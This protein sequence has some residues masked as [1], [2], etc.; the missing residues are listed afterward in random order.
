M[1]YA[2]WMHQTMHGHWLMDNRFAIDQQPGLT[3]NVYFFALGQIARFVGIPLASNLARI[4]FGVLFGYLLIQFVRRFNTGVF[5]GKLAVSLGVFGAGLGFLVWHDFGQDL[6]LDRTLW[7]KSMTLGKLPTDVWQPEGFAFPSLLTNGLFAVS[8]CLILLTLGAILDVEDP[9]CGWRPIVIGAVSIGLL[10]NIHSYDVL[11]VGLIGLGLLAASAGAKRLTWGW[12]GRVGLIVLG[13]LPGALWFVNVLTHDPVFAARAATETYAANF[14]ALVFGY[15]PLL[16][17]GVWGLVSRRGD[18][19]SRLRRTIGIGLFT[20]MFVVL[21]LTAPAEAGYALNLAGWVAVLGLALGA[22]AC[23]AEEDATYNLV[24]AWAVVGLVAPYFPGLFQ[25]KLAMGLELPWALLSAFALGDVLLSRHRGTRNLFT[26][27]LLLLIAATNIR[28]MLRELQL[29]RNDVSETTVQPAYLKAQTQRILEYLDRRSSRRCVVLCV[30][31][32]PSPD[33]DSF[34]QP[35]PDSYSSPNLPELNPILSGL[36]GVYTYAGHW[37]ET[38]DYLHR[39]QRLMR[40]LFSPRATDEQRRALIAE[41]GANYIVA[42][43]ASAFTGDT[44]ADLSNLGNVV[45]SGTAFELI[46]LATP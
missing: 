20:V 42:P 38:P 5:V 25:R 6:V 16:G 41:T 44:F 31:G 45:V 29:I 9:K 12:V 23:L 11:L 35:V 32:L 24:L 36:G 22:I 37:S 46:E 26:A 3:I 1:V 17:L 13:V 2:A 15:L 28:W 14:R 34:G 7:M 19:S 30:P 10:M 33:I 43:M 39:R 8:L 18:A 21:M 40:E 27:M 4:G